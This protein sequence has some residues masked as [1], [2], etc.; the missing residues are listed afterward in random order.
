MGTRGLTKVIRN[1]ETKVSQYGQWDHYPSG[2]GVTALEFLKNMNLEKFMSQLD[3]CRFQSDED[4]AEKT[5]F[6]A[7]IGSKDG[8]V[9]DEQSKKYDEKYP[10]DS[11][12]WGCGILEAIYNSEHDE[13]ILI[14]SN[15][16]WCEGIYTIDLDT[17]TFRVEFHDVDKTFSLDELPTEKRFLKACGENYDCEEDEST[18]TEEEVDANLL[19]DNELIIA[20]EALKEDSWDDDHILRKLANY[21]FG[22][23]TNDNI[24]QLGSIL[25]PIVTERMKVYSPHL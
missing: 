21:H 17:R 5:A 9:N 12:D 2:Q 1:A 7:S 22:I 3:K 11:R 18:T 6:L 14:E 13:I 19:S 23:D 8:W 4:R 20:V 24:N 16:D 25:L 15:D 10:Y